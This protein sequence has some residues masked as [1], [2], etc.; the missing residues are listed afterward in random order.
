MSGC[1]Q[2]SSSSFPL[3]SCNSQSLCAMPR[4]QAKG[5]SKGQVCFLLGKLEPDLLQQKIPNLKTWEY[6]CFPRHRRNTLYRN[7]SPMTQSTSQPRSSGRIL[8]LHWAQG[9]WNY[10]PN[11]F[12]TFPCPCANWSPSNPIVPYS[13]S[14]SFWFFVQC[15]LFIPHCARIGFCLLSPLHRVPTILLL[16]KGKMWIPGK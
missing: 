8:S 13:L 10:I 9:T 12:L 6:S 11:C 15:L 5:K 3:A 7:H 14:L 1:L 16:L 2:L 4:I